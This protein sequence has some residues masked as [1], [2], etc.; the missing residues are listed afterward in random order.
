MHN[1]ISFTTLVVVIILVCLCAIFAKFPL[2]VFVI[3]ILFLCLS[4]LLFF[5][6][7]RKIFY[8]FRG[9]S[10]DQEGKVNL[11]SES[12][13]AKKKLLETLP[14]KYEK[15]SFLFDVSQRLI[16][17]VDKEAIF[18]FMVTTC[19]NLFAHGNNILL[20][21]LDRKS[22]RLNLVHSLKREDSAIKE[23][24]G[25]VIE[26]WVLRHNQSLMIDDITRDF[27]FDC[28]RVVAFKERDIYSLMACP[29]SIGEKLIGIMRI[30]SKA[31][32]S[33]SLDDSRLLL[34]ICDLGAV[35][36]ERAHLF[37]TSEDLAIKDSLTSLF[38]RD[39]FFK[40]LKEE[41]T[42][43]SLRKSALGL[44][45]LDIDDFKKIND[46]YGHIIGDLVLKKLSEIL[47]ALLASQV[48]C[49]CRFGGEEF[50]FF[51]A[52]CDK[53]RLLDCAECLRRE[54]EATRVSFRRKDVHFTI[55]LGAVLYPEDSM[56]MSDLL[57]KVDTLLYQAKR[58]G[59]N[60]LCH[61]G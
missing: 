3:L 45:M 16:E 14:Q 52:E 32:L 7:K 46:T 49:A 22:D 42:R 47:S 5:R 57:S 18:D 6:I 35:V 23:K 27:R 12:I 10:D 44:V 19:A 33:F 20:F 56:E 9:Y 15:V 28:G 60:R 39:Y 13:A 43:T 31:P 2:T 30:E 11:L 61:I 4:F 41:L 21:Y 38:V 24:E 34:S 26:K 54:V 53:K 58:E 29:L 17:L 25:D 8:T 37:K 1:F 48:G 59:K 51:V 50:I 36:L 40:R 55:S